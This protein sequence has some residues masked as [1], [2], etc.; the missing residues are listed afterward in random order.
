M[1]GGTGNGQD[2]PHHLVLSHHLFSSKAGAFRLVYIYH[3]AKEQNRSSRRGDR[4][5]KALFLCSPIQGHFSPS[6]PLSSRVKL[7][8][9]CYLHKRKIFVSYSQRTKWSKQ[10]TRS[11]RHYSFV[12]L[13]KF[14]LNLTTLCRLISQCLHNVLKLCRDIFLGFTKA[15]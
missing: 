5:T 3:L 13:F 6:P 2:C 4:I 7:G 9:E 14:I 11:Q 1:G 15:T 10:E 12:H 8:S